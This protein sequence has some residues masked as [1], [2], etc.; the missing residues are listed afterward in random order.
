MG[1]TSSLTLSDEAKFRVYGTELLRTMYG[2]T[3]Y[4]NTRESGKD[5]NHELDDLRL[6]GRPN[7]IR[8]LKSRRLR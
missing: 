7:I 5:F 2:D 1:D 6:Y 8:I 3:Q 4:E